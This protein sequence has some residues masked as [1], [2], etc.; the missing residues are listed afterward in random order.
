MLLSSRG[1]F[2]EGGQQMFIFTCNEGCNTGCCSIWQIFSRICG[3][4]GC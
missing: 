4:F 1:I 2:Y 3:G